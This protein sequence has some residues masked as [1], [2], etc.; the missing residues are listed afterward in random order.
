MNKIIE[1]A[2]DRDRD[3]STCC[4]K[5][6]RTIEEL[7]VCERRL[8]GGGTRKDSKTGDLYG[9]VIGSFRNLIDRQGRSIRSHCDGSCRRFRC[10]SR[11]RDG[12]S[13]AG[14]CDQ[15]IDYVANGRARSY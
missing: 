2:C 15:A 14:E 12:R 1:T 13:G 5:E 10:I 3:A 9:F 11:D 8:S 6:I 4:S 7:E